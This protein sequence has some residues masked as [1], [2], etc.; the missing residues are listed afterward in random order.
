MGLYLDLQ[1]VAFLLFWGFYLAQAVSL[2][3]AEAGGRNPFR[4]KDP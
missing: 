3:P 4:E 1:W 2:Q